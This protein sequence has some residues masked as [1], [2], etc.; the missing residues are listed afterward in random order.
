MI[1]P[2]PFIIFSG[3]SLIRFSAVSQIVLR[4]GELPRIKS[5]KLISEHVSGLK[6]RRK[7]ISNR[8]LGYLLKNIIVLLYFKTQAYF[9]YRQK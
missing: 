6:N 2:C 9:S 8:Y 5:R 7:L 4:S 1:M 3:S